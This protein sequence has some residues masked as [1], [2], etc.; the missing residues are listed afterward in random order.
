MADEWYYTEQGQQ[1][2]PISRAELQQLAAT[3]RLR[4]TDLVWN[5]GL[6]N[7]IPA[8]AADGLF[9]AA[10]ARAPAWPTD[11]LDANSQAPTRLVGADDYILPRRPRPIEDED[12]F[13]A[14]PRSRR[15]KRSSSTG[16]IVGLVV[17]GVVL[18]ALAVFVVVL[19]VLTLGRDGTYT[20]SL[21]PGEQD[22]R[23]RYFERGTRVTIAVK[24]E[25][26]SDVDL[27][28]LDSNRFP[29]AQDDGPEPDCFVDFVAPTDGNYRIVVI[30]RGPGANRSRVTITTGSVA[31][32]PEF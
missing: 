4:P 26:R 14:P 13:D 12:D 23:G 21:R 30:N 19:V 20:V 15:P 31:D 11:E 28:V 32:R 9:A 3:R 29:V 16:L 17:G 24:S 22:D 5:E 27:Y 1:R 2:G 6:A 10:P 7:W 18:V 25:R 8:G